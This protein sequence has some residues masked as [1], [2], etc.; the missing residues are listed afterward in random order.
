MFNIYS[1]TQ[2]QSTLGNQ[3]EETPA[4]WTAGHHKIR[5]T[6]TWKEAAASL[7]ATWF[8]SFRINLSHPDPKQ[9][10]KHMEPSEWIKKMISPTWTTGYRHWKDIHLIQNGAYPLMHVGSTQFS[11][12][13][14]N[15]AHWGVN[16]ASF[17]RKHWTPRWIFSGFWWV[18]YHTSHGS[19]PQPSTSGSTPKESKESRDFHV[20]LLFPQASVFVL[21][22]WNVFLEDS[23]VSL[24]L[25]NL[26]GPFD[27][28]SHVY[29][30][31]VE[32][33]ESVPIIFSWST[34]MHLNI[35]QLF[36]RILEAINQEVNDSWYFAKWH[37]FWC[38]G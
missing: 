35:P 27:L 24:W 3:L 14:F 30:S 28:A 22:L 2:G 29:I 31:G 23:L 36:V 6:M 15:P 13:G 12:T 19:K 38:I 32:D 34:C 1:L 26:Q 11:I 18:E 33:V 10:Q 4:T 21:A 20:F 37:A 9:S 7:C 25:L 5:G 8:H 16:S 17:L